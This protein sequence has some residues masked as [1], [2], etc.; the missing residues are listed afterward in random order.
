MNKRT[1]IALL[2]LGNLLL[3]IGFFFLPLY[4][5]PYNNHGNLLN[6]LSAWNL[7]N[8]PSAWNLLNGP[9]AWNLL[10]GPSAWN[11]LNGPLR[12]IF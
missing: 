2:F 8:G 12:G 10:N 4:V 5:L 7:L 3:L 11:L 9:S 1:N 6:G